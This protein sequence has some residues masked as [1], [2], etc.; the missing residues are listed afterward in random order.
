MEKK[1][2]LLHFMYGLSVFLG[3]RLSQDLSAW[4]RVSLRGSFKLRLV[5]SA[6]FSMIDC[7]LEKILIKAQVFSIG[8][9]GK[10]PQVPALAFFYL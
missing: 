1:S 8:I 5:L 4:V 9:P 7:Y 6:I 10:K 3:T 2:Y